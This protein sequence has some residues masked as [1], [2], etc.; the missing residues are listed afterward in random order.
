ML[1][2]NQKNFPVGDQIYECQPGESFRSIS[3]WT[4]LF[5]CSKPTTIKFFKMLENDGMI[6]TKNS[7]ERKPKETPVNSG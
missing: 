4:D 3:K 5:S 7:G 6:F 1:I 2:T